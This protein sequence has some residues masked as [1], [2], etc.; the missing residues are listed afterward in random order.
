MHGELGKKMEEEWERPLVHESGHALIAVLEG[1]PCYGICFEKGE[2]IAR[3]CALIAPPPPAKGPR[4]TTWFLP[5]DLLRSNSSTGAPIRGS[6]EGP[7]KL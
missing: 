2:G 4:A 3:L 7:E 5:Q 6:L 1:I